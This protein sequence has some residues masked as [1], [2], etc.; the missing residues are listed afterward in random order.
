V[1]NQWR[2][3]EHRIVHDTL[4]KI[5]GSAS[6]FECVDKCGRTAL[7]WSWKHDTDPNIIDNYEPRCRS[8]HGWYDQ[9]KLTSEQREEI[10][11][12]FGSIS[13]R[14]AGKMYGV[15]KNTI[16]RVWRQSGLI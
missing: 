8:C 7:D 9:S 5:R 14:K 3:K 16:K 13:S 15:D 12:L 4:Q 2:T 6:A 1:S 10:K 11:I